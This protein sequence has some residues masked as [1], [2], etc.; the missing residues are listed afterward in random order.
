MLRELTHLDRCS[1]ANDLSFLNGVSTDRT[2]EGLAYEADA[3]R[4]DLL[5]DVFGSAPASPQQSAFREDGELPGV[6]R[7]TA[8]IATTA[9][10]P[11]DIPRLRSI[12]V[13][14]GYREGLATSK[15]QY[16]QEGFDEGYSLGGEI[17]LKAGWCLGV[18]ESLT[19]ST[20]RRA[21][22]EAKR[23]EID[24]TYRQAKEELSMT[25]LLGEEYFA[26]DGV[27]KY[28]VEG[29]DASDEELKVTFKHVGAAHPLLKRWEH[30]IDKL[31]SASVIGA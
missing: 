19:H 9:A 18:L 13:T 27:W 25:A 1:S 30:E 7:D 22:E 4:I 21:V 28:D 23:K 14:N 5:D 26:P 2:T 11:S 20:R 12:H 24:E 6:G 16:I 10:D 31:R 29:Q 3:T 8:R 15:E 17:G